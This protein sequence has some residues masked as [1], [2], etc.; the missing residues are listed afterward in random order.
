MTEKLFE[1]SG[2]TV[3]VTGVYGT[4]SV[5]VLLLFMTWWLLNRK[6]RTGQPIFA[7]QVMN[8]IGFGLLP[9]LAF[10]K[11][12]QDISMG[13][14]AAVTEPLPLVRWLTEDGC[15]RPMRIEM[16]AAICLFVLLCLWL[17]LRKEEFPDNGD[18]LMIA[19]CIWS[20]IRLVT[21]DFRA[22]PQILFHISSCVMIMFCLIIWIFRRAQISRMLLRTAADLA[23]VSLC[24]AVNLLTATGTLTAGSGIADFA[25]KTGSALLALILTLIV[26]GDVRKLKKRA[27]QPG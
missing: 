24:I 20:A 5:I 12:F 15:Y 3:T 4:L 27:D 7:G 19:V 13:K 25:V 26:G 2:V 1:F 14:G 11:A 21:E 9:A 10:L 16:A 17:I 6:K 18:L 22:E 8:G 23:A